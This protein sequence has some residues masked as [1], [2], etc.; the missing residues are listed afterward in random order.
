MESQ[1]NPNGFRIDNE[2]SETK[3]FL[4]SRAKIELI[5]LKFDLLVHLESSTQARAQPV[6]AV[7]DVG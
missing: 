1:K 2:P 4:R 6:C 3:T 7:V 5:A